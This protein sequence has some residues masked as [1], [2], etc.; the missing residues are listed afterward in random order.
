MN[1][2]LGIVPVVAVLALAG[3]TAEPAQ[4]E[5][6]STVSAPFEH[7]VTYSVTSD[8]K[9]VSVTYSTFS[10]GKYGSSSAN[11]VPAPWS[12]SQKFK[13]GPFDYT[14]LDVYASADETAT[15]ITCE[16]QVDGKT[17]SQQ[18]AVGP[19]SSVSCMDAR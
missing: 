19:Y 7:T 1:T 3:C 17:I 8:G 18:A 12:T 6:S 5:P 10:S 16:I 9:T 4:S 15:K 2:Y 13:A 14:S 11:G